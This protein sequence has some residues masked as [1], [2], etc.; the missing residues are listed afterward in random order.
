MNSWVLGECLGTGESGEV[1]LVTSK[2]SSAS[3]GAF[4][5]D[6]STIPPGTYACKIIRRCKFPVP[7]GLANP[8]S[9]F[10][11]TSQTSAGPDERF[12]REIRLLRQLNHP[13]ITSLK[14]VITCPV[15]FY[16]FMEYVPGGDLRTFVFQRKE[17]GL[18]PMPEGQIRRIFR[19]ICRAVLYLHDHDIVHRDLKLENILLTKDDPPVVKVAD[20]G[21]AKEGAMAISQMSTVCGTPT[22]WA[23]G[24][25]W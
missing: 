2:Q 17:R 13:N 15:N 20:L 23:P 3:H 14:G 18:G 12:H 8:S 10:G 9:P 16:I 22:Y 11:D 4:E 24:R 7:T 19:Q 25:S 21:V 6:D 1:R 5:A